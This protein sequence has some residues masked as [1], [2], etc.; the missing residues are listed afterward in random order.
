MTSNTD[1]R[2]SLKNGH[3]IYFLIY[4]ELEELLESVERI[5][6][7]LSMKNSVNAYFS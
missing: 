6:S 3:F 4:N 2:Q 5:A 7:H 1:F